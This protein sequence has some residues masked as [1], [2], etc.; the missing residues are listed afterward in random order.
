MARVLG[1]LLALL[2][3]TTHAAPRAKKPANILFL[4]C[5]SMD[6]R[7]LDPTSPVSQR[8]EMP[9]LRKLA[10]IGT[11]FVRTYAA[12]PQCVP[13]RTTMFAGR[14]ID[15]VRTWNNDQGLAA[16]PGPGGALDPSCLKNYD[17]ARCAELAAA[18]GLKSTLADSLQ[19]AG[20]ELC[21]FGKVDVGA[22]IIEHNESTTAGW[23][24]GQPGPPS[25]FHSGTSLNTQGRAADIRKPTKPTPISITN[26]HDNNVHAED[27]KMIKKCAEWFESHDP[28]APAP[29]FH[30]CSVNIPHPAFNTNATWLAKVKTELIPKPFWLPES[31]FHPA[32]KYMSMSKNVWGTDISDAEILQVRKTYYAMC[33]ETDWMLGTVMD[34]ANRTGHLDDTYIVFVSDHGEMNMEHRQVWKNSMYEASE[35]VPLIIAGPGVP[36]GVVVTNLTSLL[37][38]Y[39]TLMGMVGGIAP[40]YLE[41]HT[42]MPWLVDDHKAASLF[43]KEMAVR[44]NWVTAQYHSNMGNTGSFMLRQGPWKL[45]TFGQNGARFNGSCGEDCSYPPQ[46][47][48]VESD[49]DEI[50]D[51]SRTDAGKAVVMAMDKL[52]NSVV[53]YQA[54]DLECK[55][56]DKKLYQKFIEQTRSASICFN[57]FV[58]TSAAP[59]TACNPL[60]V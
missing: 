41:G 38:I 8:M 48:N 50:K 7:V 33:A 30:Y 16:A 51:V 39:P 28:G 26:D 9:N 45:I 40:S 57:G 24:D 20:C 31:E 13:S 15:Q 42:L 4:M 35:R 43:S 47:F 22:G 53:D 56:E 44:P 10:S 59:S 36:Q 29:W 3:A 2:A 60:A 58:S 49:P 6:G 27:Q 25:G 21:I 18:Q 55:R 17:E 37:D 23:I 5:D 11:N 14:R 32:D 34:A 12:S 19:G 46:L 1:L 54:V 52:L